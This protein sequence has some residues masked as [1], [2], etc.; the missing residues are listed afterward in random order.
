ME[1]VLVIGNCGVGKS[2]FAKQLAVH[3]GLP[4]VHL[5]AY[6]WQPNWQKPTDEQW[7]ETLQNLLNKECW[8]MDGNYRSTLAERLQYADTVFF[9]DYSTLRA[10]GG[11]FKRFLFSVFGKQH[12]VDAI[13]GCK[14]K[15]DLQFIRWV[16]RYRK[17]TRPLLYKVLQENFTGKVIVFKNRKELEDYVSFLTLA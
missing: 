7:Q 10:L 8:I 1:R 16:L 17:T 3:T 6:Y 12:R 2:T 5:D 15:I 4:L 13:E 14:E 11:V 9:L